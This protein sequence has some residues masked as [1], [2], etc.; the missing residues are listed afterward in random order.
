MAGLLSAQ[1][2][3]RERMVFDPT[4]H[5]H[6]HVHASSIV[7][8]ADGE[9]LAVW[10]ENGPDLPDQYYSLDADKSDNVRIGG[11]RMPADASSWNKPFVMADTYGISD[12]NPTL[13]VDREGRLWLFYPTLIGVPQATWGSGLLQYRVSNNPSGS[14]PPKWDLTNI[15]LVHPN[16]LDEVVARTANMLRSGA[17]RQNTNQRRAESMLERLSDP[18]ARRLGWM[19]RAHP[20]QLSDGAVLLPFSNENFNVPAMAITRDGGRSWTFSNVVPG[21]G[22]TQPSVVETEPGKLIAFFRDARGARR[23]LRSDSEDGGMSWSEIRPTS[24][25]NPGAGIEAVRLSNGKLAMVYNPL[26]TSP[27]DKLGIA[28]SDDNGETWKWTR[29]LEDEPDSRFDYPSIVQAKDGSLHITYS[30][31]LKTIKHVQVNEEWIREGNR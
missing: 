25:P 27:R 30:Y 10:Y 31:N 14:G 1:P 29:L 21:M 23:I 28:L 6:G 11:A 3:Y 22:A 18:F 2:L 4:D 8:L 7:Q 9:M 19:P 12:N 26:E 17:D 16:G 20:I 13:L 15:L 5:R 24:L